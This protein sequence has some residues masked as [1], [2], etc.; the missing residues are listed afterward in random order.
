MPIQLKSTDTS[1]WT[2]QFEFADMKI[3]ATLQPD[4]SLS[5]Q[6]RI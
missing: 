1:T 4:G 6:L 5:A 2:E 3:S